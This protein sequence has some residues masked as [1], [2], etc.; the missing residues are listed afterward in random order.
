E[1]DAFAH[2]T[3]AFYFD[4]LDDCSAALTGALGATGWRTDSLV[5]RYRHELRANDGLHAE[6][7]VVAAEARALTLAHK[8]FNSVTGDVTTLVEQRLVPDAGAAPPAIAERVADWEVAE[9]TPDELP[10][11]FVPT[12]RS[13]VKPGEL[14]ATGAL[15]WSA[16]V[17]RFSACNPHLLSNIGMTP[18][19]MRDAKQGFS[20]FETRLTLIGARPKAGDLLAIRSGIVRLGKSSVGMVHQMIDVRAD[21][22]VATFHQAGVQLDMVA[23]RSKPWPDDIRRAGEALLGRASA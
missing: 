4:R 18:G 22:P 11:A 19:Y 17:H 12:G 16:F 13:L 2:F 23:R 14:D 1:C 21:R 6:S 3:I 15:A 5:V 8:F 20:T 7:G 9:P 10:G